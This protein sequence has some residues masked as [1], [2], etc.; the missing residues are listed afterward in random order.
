MEPENMRELRTGIDV[1]I[2]LF[3]ALSGQLAR[4]KTVKLGRYREN[5][6][7]TS[8]CGLADTNRLCSSWRVL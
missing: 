5:K 1:N 4:D 3:T 7:T 2:T 6:E 8:Y